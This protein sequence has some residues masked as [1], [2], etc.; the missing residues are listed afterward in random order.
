M[1]ERHLETL[2]DV[3]DRSQAFWLRCA[4]CAHCWIGA[5]VPTDVSTLCKL[6]K[7]ARCPKCAAG[8]PFIAKQNAGVLMEKS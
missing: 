5:Y 1:V 2:M 7:C 8:K 3:P 4:K 6:T